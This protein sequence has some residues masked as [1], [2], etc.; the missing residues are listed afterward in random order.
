MEKLEIAKQHLLPK[1]IKEHGLNKSE[2]SLS[3]KELL[4]IIRSYTR[5][6]GVR[7]LERQ[8][9]KIFRKSVKERVL[10]DSKKAE[11]ATYRQQ[12][13]DLPQQWPADVDKVNT[14]P[15]NGETLEPDTEN[16]INVTVRNRGSQ[17]QENVQVTLEI[18]CSNS[19]YTFTDSYTVE[20]LSS[21][22]G[23][24]VTFE[25]DTPSDEDYEY[26]IKSKAVISDDEKEENNEK[27]ISV[28]TY[29]TYDLELSNARV[30]PMIAEKEENRETI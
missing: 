22:S 15:K 5:E 6:A 21:G 29:V 10:S 4:E 25:W 7:G 14:N 17:D 16:I 26:Q 1:V 28:N 19:S 20:D 3:D 9:A 2:F 30:I 24:T 27:V 12:L 11:W 18:T 13:R 23:T 8:I